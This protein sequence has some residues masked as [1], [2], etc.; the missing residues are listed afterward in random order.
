[1]IISHKHRFIFF[2]VPKTATHAIRDALRKVMGPDDWEQQMLSGQQALPIPELARI[3]HGHISATELTPFIP[4]EM[5]RDY[6]KF[7]FVRNPFDRFIS[8]CFFL[9]RDN[10]Q[11]EQQAHGFLRRALHVP[12][13]RQRVLVRPQHAQLES[14]SGQIELDAVGR[15]ESLQSSFDT[16]CEKIGVPSRA[17][18][19]KNASQHKDYTE[20]FDDSLRSDVAAFYAGDLKAFDYDYP[21]LGKSQA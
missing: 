18:P 11:F 21:F 3:R 2:A 14:S 13:F 17:L 9:N 12:R 7:A 15:Y 4:D 20:Y 1:M 5:W 8:T 16:I 10:P 6:F 19:V